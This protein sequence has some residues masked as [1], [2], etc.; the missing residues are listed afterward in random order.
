MIC[1]EIL[2]PLGVSALPCHFNCLNCFL[3]AKPKEQGTFAPG[4][5]ASAAGGFFELRCFTGLHSAFRTDAINIAC[6]AD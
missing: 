6:G 2:K 5:V 1:G 3:R 4:G